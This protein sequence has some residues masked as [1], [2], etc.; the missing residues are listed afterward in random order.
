MTDTKQTAAVPV[1][2][3][4]LGRQWEPGEFERVSLETFIGSVEAN[5]DNPE[6]LAVLCKSQREAAGLPRR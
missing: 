6:W 1:A 2:P 4:S 3:F 5:L